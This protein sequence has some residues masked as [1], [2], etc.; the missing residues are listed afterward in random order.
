MKSK[1]FEL[2]PGREPREPWRFVIDPAVVGY[3]KE[4]WRSNVCM[5]WDKNST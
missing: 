3:R 2:Q 4:V 1:R 5:H